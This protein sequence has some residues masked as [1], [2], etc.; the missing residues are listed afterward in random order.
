MSLPRGCYGASPQTATP[1]CSRARTPAF[2]RDDDRAVAGTFA[3]TSSPRAPCAAAL[4]RC[5]LCRCDTEPLSCITPDPQVVGNQLA[6]CWWS[7]TWRRMRGWWSKQEDLVRRNRAR[8]QRN[9]SWGSKRR[10][11][12]G[13]VLRGAAELDDRPNQRRVAQSS[14]AVILEHGGAAN[15]RWTR[16]T[17]HGAKSL[18]TRQARRVNTLGYLDA[19][20]RAGKHHRT[21]QRQFRKATFRRICALFS[22]AVVDLFR[23][24]DG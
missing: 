22:G 20:Y 15:L 12:G 8:K 4:R 1:R 6:R 11:L 2:R 18:S 21:V 14:I 9:G 19:V 5:I 16:I 10:T 7:N 23:D 17:D 13:S 24:L 3:V